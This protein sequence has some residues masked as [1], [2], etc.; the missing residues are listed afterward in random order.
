MPLPGLAVGRFRLE[1]AIPAQHRRI[2]GTRE[3]HLKHHL[4]TGA[5]HC[6]RADQIKLPH[7]AK[8]LVIKFGDTRPVLLETAIPLDER[9]G[10]MHAQDLHVADPEVLPLGRREDFRQRRRIGPGKNI[11]AQPG[12]G[13]RRRTHVADTVQHR[14]TIVV[15]F[16]IDVPEEFVVARHADMFEHTDGHDPVEAARDFAVIAQ[17]KA[18]P[19][20]QPGGPGPLDG[21]AM[22]FLADA[23]SKLERDDEAIALA[24]QY[25]KHERRVSGASDGRTV[26]GI[27][28]LGWMLDRIYPPFWFALS[29]LNQVKRLAVLTAFNPWRPWKDKRGFVGR[30]RLKLSAPDRGDEFL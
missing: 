2:A 23:L 5:E 26:Q 7:A 19:V 24:R 20:R 8:P 12:A 18:Y 29:D 3:L 10:I 4:R 17:F 28:L 13:R 30:R 11:F 1:D 27:L 16:F 22:L 6:F 25:V 14:E 15:E 21:D 9:V